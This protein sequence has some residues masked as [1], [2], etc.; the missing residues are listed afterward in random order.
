MGS[1]WHDAGKGEELRRI[2]LAR[3]VVG[4]GRGSPARQR[5]RPGASAVPGAAPEGLVTLG[6]NKTQVTDGE[7]AALAPF[8]G[9]HHLNL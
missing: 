1:L 6:L 9:L 8:A 7:P 2:G 3:G 5:R 4:A